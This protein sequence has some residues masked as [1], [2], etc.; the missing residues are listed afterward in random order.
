MAPT[1]AEIIHPEVEGNPRIHTGVSVYLFGKSSGWTLLVKKSNAPMELPIAQDPDENACAAVLSGLVASGTPVECAAR[2]AV[3]LCAALTDDASPTLL[4]GLVRLAKKKVARRGALE[5]LLLC[6]SR[7]NSSWASVLRVRDVYEREFGEVLVDAYLA[8]RDWLRD[9]LD[10]IESKPR[11]AQIALECASGERLA[12]IVGK[13]TLENWNGIS[14]SALVLVVCEVAKHGTVNPLLLKRVQQAFVDKSPATA[15]VCHV[16]PSVK[17]SLVGD[18]EEETEFSRML[19]AYND[20]STNLEQMRTPEQAFAYARVH[21]LPVPKIAAAYIASPCDTEIDPA[22]GDEVVTQPR[23]LR[24]EVDDAIDN[25][26]SAILSRIPSL[27][28]MYRARKGDDLV[29]LALRY[30][31]LVRRRV[32]EVSACLYVLVSGLS[33]A[34]ERYETKTLGGIQ[35][36]LQVLAMVMRKTRAAVKQQEHVEQ[37]VLGVI[38]EAVEFVMAEGRSENGVPDMFEGVVIQL[39][40]VLSV[41]KDHERV[42]DLVGKWARIRDAKGSSSKVRKSIDN[43]LAQVCDVPI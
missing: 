15:R 41:Y 1:I 13:L 11:P 2:N 40:S 38:F 34:E 39:V 3:H 33:D 5:A 12:Q 17:A 20:N 36:L 22:F 35:I 8:P 23:W 10:A 25:A 14:R 37:E 26:L 42:Q 29:T 19:I 27:Q 43:F 9:R 21:N 28:R 31:W 6:G 4:D 7:S 32:E 18:A 16:V 30:P 24:G